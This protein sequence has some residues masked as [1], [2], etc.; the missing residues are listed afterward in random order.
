MID[1]GRGEA[2]GGWWMAAGGRCEA[3]GEW[4]MVDGGKRGT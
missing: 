3:G 4:R 1:S 2:G